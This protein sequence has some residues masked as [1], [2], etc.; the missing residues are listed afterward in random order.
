MSLSNTLITWGL[1]V[2]CLIW[3]SSCSKEAEDSTGNGTKPQE[4]K[5]I[6]K[7]YFKG[8]VEKGPF[9]S[10]SAVVC[11]ELT[12]DLAQTGRSF[13]ATLNNNLGE[14]NFKSLKLESSLVQLH[15]SGYFFS[16]LTG[17][18]SKSTLSLYALSDI[19]D[20]NSANVNLLTHMQKL[21]I[22][23]LVEQGKSFKE[24]RDQSFKEVGKSFYLTEKH[25]EGMVAENISL[26]GGDNASMVLLALSAIVLEGK[27]EAEL[28]QFLTNYSGDLSDNGVI[29]SEKIRKTIQESSYRLHL[30]DDKHKAPIDYIRENVEKRYK[31]LGKKI[32]IGDF[33]Q[34]I[35]HN[36]NA[37][38]SDYNMRSPTLY[39]DGILV[40]KNSK[41]VSTAQIMGKI[42]GNGTLGYTLKSITVNDASYARVTG[43]KPNLGLELLRLGKFTADV[44]L[45]HANYLDVTIKGAKLVNV[46]DKTYGGV[47]DDYVNSII[48]G[49]DGHL[50]LVGDKKSKGSGYYDGWLLKLDKSDGSVLL[51][52]TYG[53]VNGSSRALNSIL[54]DSDG[55]LWLVGRTPKGAHGDYDGWLLKLDKSGNKVLEKTYGGSGYD[56][57]RG[58]IEGRDGHLWLVGRTPRRGP[59]GFDAW[60][61]K[62]DKSDG[63]VLLDK[64]YG[65]A[66]EDYFHGI[67]EGSDGHIWLVGETRR[68]GSRIDAWLLKLDKSGNKVLEKTYGGG[69]N[70]WFS[71]ILEGSD[72]SI[73]VGGGTSSKGSWLLKLDKSGNKVLEKTYGG[74]SNGWFSSILEGSDGSI[75]VGGSTSSKGSGGS[76]GWLLKLN[77]VDGS[78]LLDKTYGGSRDDVFNSIIKGRDGSIRVGGSTSSKGS[79]GSD[80]WLLGGLDYLD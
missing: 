37:D 14:F 24:A 12:P 52:K 46:L 80:G 19:E 53:N 72:G 69:S 48:E 9:V 41:K 79:G 23:K 33:G 5:V 34:Y 58:I 1:C 11:N 73:W 10:G 51:E 28:T 77:K 54:G 38:L 45:E 7:T 68:R 75:W 3:F 55:H 50:W 25:L 74:G 6:E 44:V 4:K 67:I 60:L 39:F 32:T 49:R 64:T 21:R 57:F 71:S 61:L 8:L 62:L 56:N 29:D 31:D 78:V 18:L 27:S 15:V 70:G 35:D 47:N 26:T 16:E 76:D 65:G 42:K 43:V 59:G 30:W 17:K 36:R 40:S 22:E 13:S 63:S 20:K 66:Q 2:A